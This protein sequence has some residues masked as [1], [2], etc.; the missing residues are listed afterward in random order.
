MPT[1]PPL[2]LIASL[3]PAGFL[4]VLAA[5]NS[6]PDRPEPPLHAMPEFPPIMAGT[7]TFADGRLAVRVT[8]AVP[9]GH[10]FGQGGE[11]AGGSPSGRHGGGGGRRG[12][13]NLS[14]GMGM[15]GGGE[16][17]AGG[18]G[19]GMGGDSHPEGMGPSGDAGPRR[20]PMVG[21]QSMVQLKL[22][23]TNTSATDAV[24][25]EVLDFKSAL[26]D[27]A[28]FPAKYQVAAGESAASEIM[29]S[30]LGL[31]SAEI[32]VTVVLRIGDHKETKVVTV[33]LLPK[34]ESAAKEPT[35]VGK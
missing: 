30:Q 17:R 10:G 14:M 8:M 20:G 32:P 33:R 5:C 7:E 1:V 23:F 29:T 25:C 27:F 28:V 12:G 6:E 26:G 35:S 21:G 19:G 13:G 4:L 22:H 11:A 15:G 18:M 34:P 3:I 24:S 31:N 9:T 16:G 2:R